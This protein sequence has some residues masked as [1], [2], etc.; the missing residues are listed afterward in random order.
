MVLLMF[1][2][3]CRKYTPP[4]CKKG[5]NVSIKFDVFSLGVIILDIVAGKEGYSL[6]S[7]KCYKESHKA[8]IDLVRKLLSSKLTFVLFNPA[9]CVAPSD[10]I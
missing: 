2:V 10:I 1:T 5:G 8:F 3:S 7:T 4:E 9:L 6:R